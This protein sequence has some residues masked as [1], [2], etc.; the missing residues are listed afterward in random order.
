MFLWLLKN[1][2]TNDV[3][4]RYE[5]TM[6]NR[7]QHSQF[8]YINI[9]TNPVSGVIIILLGESYNTRAIVDMVVVAIW[10]LRLKRHPMMCVCNRGFFKC[11]EDSD[12]LK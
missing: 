1:L 12:D 11:F 2:G 4:L 9:L 3:P 7:T 10:I 5:Y 8:V 6:S